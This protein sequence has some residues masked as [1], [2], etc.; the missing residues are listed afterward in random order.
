M[1]TTISGSLGTTKL[2]FEGIYDLILIKDIF[3]SNDGSSLEAY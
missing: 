2:T 3:K 1:I